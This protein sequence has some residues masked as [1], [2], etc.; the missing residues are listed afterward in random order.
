VHDQQVTAAR[1]A[2]GDL[3]LAVERLGRV[4]PASVDLRRLSEDV[5]RIPVDLDLLTG[6]TPAEPVPSGNDRPL[7]VIPDGEYPAHLFADADD[8]GLGPRRG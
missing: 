5:S 1:K 2:A 4:Y 6:T 8:E 3:A 7:E